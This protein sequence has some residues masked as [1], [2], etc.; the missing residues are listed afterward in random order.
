MKECKG[1]IY[2]ECLTSSIQDLALSNDFIASIY[3]SILKFSPKPQTIFIQILCMYYTV[4]TF[5]IHNMLNKNQTNYSHLS[6]V[7][8]DFNNDNII[9]IFYYILI[10]LYA[11]SFCYHFEH[12]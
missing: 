11:Y 8:Y 2:R 12:F 1:N 5:N 3:D 9:K 10:I 7:K 6:R 4:H